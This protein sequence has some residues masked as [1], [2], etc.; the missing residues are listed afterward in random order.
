MNRLDVYVPKNHSYRRKR[1]PIDKS[2]VAMMFFIF[3][4]VVGCG[5]G[6]WVFVTGAIQAVANALGR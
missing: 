4:L 6:A 1:R 5:Y 3:V 2:H